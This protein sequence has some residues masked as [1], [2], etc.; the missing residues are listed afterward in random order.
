MARLSPTD[1]ETLKSK[2]TPDERRIAFEEGTEAPGSHPYNF[3][4]RDGMY[5]CRVCDS[6]LFPASTKY[7]SGS[8]WPSFYAAID[9]DAVE[10]KTDFK[11]VMP[12]TEIH[13]ATCGAH[14]G[15]VFNDGPEPTGLRF[16]TNGTALDFKPETTQE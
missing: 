15:H 4:K 2:L 13:C 5:H 12:R 10:T 11:L 14:L 7:E 1:I 3:E 16:C 8:G 9:S 6:A